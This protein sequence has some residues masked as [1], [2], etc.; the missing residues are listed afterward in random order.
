M[1]I[2]KD[3]RGATIL[4]GG[5]WGSDVQSSSVSS[6]WNLFPSDS[7]TYDSA[8]GCSKHLGSGL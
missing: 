2:F 1:K 5:D 3:Q 6:L 7:S 4:L 8:R